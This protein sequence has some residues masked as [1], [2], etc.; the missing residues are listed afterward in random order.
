MLPPYHEG[1][2][3]R[4]DD[5]LRYTRRDIVGVA[6]PIF[7][8]RRIPRDTDICRVRGPLLPRGENE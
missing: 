3:S 7:A 6:R 8:I 2:T 5:M 4:A 1:F